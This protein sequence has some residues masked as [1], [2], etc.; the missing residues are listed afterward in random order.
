[1]HLPTTHRFHGPR[2]SAFTLV[3]IMVVMALIAV[4]LS[5]SLNVSSAWKAQKLVAQARQLASECSQA[6]LLAQ[7]D[8]YPVE[9]RF[10]QL[11]DELGSGSGTAFRAY[12]L[13]KLIGYEPSSG[14]AIY[15]NLTEVKYFEDDIMLHENSQYTT[16]KDLAVQSPPDDAVPLRGQTRSYVSFMF[17][18]DGTTTL[19][20][21]PD[22][23]FTF[24]KESELRGQAS[25]L[26][27]N[28]RS[29]V[30]QPVTAQTS[31]Y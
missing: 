22:A 26:P 19:N 25:T 8:N 7:K 18:P 20:R 4:L 27:D 9:I 5:L 31:V 16:V 17:L 29:M 6:S 2:P 14:K 11:P 21:S 28:Y 23:V 3:E 30:L 12:N 10:Y 24:V 13:V 15:T 1:M